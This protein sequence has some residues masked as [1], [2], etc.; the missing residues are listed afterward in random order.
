MT[1]RQIDA[2]RRLIAERQTLKNH[3]IDMENEGKPK[4]KQLSYPTCGVQ[5]TPT[6]YQ[7]VSLAVGLCI[8]DPIPELPEDDE[9]DQ[10]NYIHRELADQIEH[11][12]YY[13]VEQPFCGTVKP[14]HLTDTLREYEKCIR[15]EQGRRLIHLSAMGSNGNEIDGWFNTKYVRWAA[16]AVGGTVR[17]YIGRHMKKRQPLPFLI[18]TPDTNNCWDLS[19]GIHALVMPVRHG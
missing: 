12:D 6:G 15:M 17:F 14:S 9:P 13:M 18:V 11:G 1:K 16:E 4:K 5:K 2:M 8:S 7:L 3:N 10:Y 19:E